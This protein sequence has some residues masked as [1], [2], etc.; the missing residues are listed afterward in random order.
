[1][2]VLTISRQL[3]AGGTKLGKLISK[4][5]GYTFIDKEITELVAEKAKVSKN[6]VQSIEKEVGGTLHKFI[7][8]LVSKRYLD[9]IL[10]DSKGYIDEEIYVD[11]L[12]EVIA[13]IADQGNVGILGGGG[14]YVLSDREDTRH[15][16]LI[17]DKPDRIRFMEE[18]YDLP[19]AQA[20]NLVNDH[21]KRRLNV[22]RKY[23]KVDHDT[24]E[25][26]D[27]VL[28]MSKLSMDAACNLVVDL[29]NKYT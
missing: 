16:L 17:A 18:N 2:P 12:R 9:R 26:Y 1:M 5:T 22:I 7:S 27:L 29:L 20:N 11:T 21:D 14:Q 13:K 24:P 6:W 4:K 10:D 23:C 25:L 28:N 19:P 3:G 15:L 8:G